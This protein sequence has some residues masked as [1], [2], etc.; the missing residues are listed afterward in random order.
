MTGKR[1][2]LKPKQAN[3]EVHVYECLG[4]DL[5][6]HRASHIVYEIRNNELDGFF[7][8]CRK[9]EP[10]EQYVQHFIDEWFQLTEGI[11]SEDRKVIYESISD[12]DNY[13]K[14]INMTRTHIDGVPAYAHFVDYSSSPL[15]V[16]LAL[17]ESDSDLVERMK[18]F[19]GTCA[20]GEL[21]AYYAN[22]AVG[23]NEYQ[24]VETSK[25]VASKEMSNLIGLKDMMPSVRYI[26]IRLDNG[27]EKFGLFQERAVGVGYKVPDQQYRKEHITPE[28]QRTINNLSLLDVINYERDHSPNN[29]NVVLKDSMIV[30]ICSYDNSGSG[31]MGLHRDVDFR[32]L[33]NNSEYIHPKTGMVNRPYIDKNTADTVLSLK[34][35]DVLNALN[36]SVSVFQAYCAWERVK[37]VKKAIRLTMKNNPSFALS[38]N[39]WNEQ[40]IE[41]EISGKYGK[42]ALVEYLTQCLPPEE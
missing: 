29:Y 20:S 13:N 23:Y 18:Y 5:V 41:E 19:V 8:E 11:H 24:T 32:S 35:K 15:E 37:K 7:R 22:A 31:C 16:G 40:T 10:L 9:H 3:K 36:S 26:R 6:F 34:R 33:K 2:L 39:Q 25:L 42:T 28:F 27:I 30:G 17:D 12:P 4:S 14:F 21:F 1:I 38:N